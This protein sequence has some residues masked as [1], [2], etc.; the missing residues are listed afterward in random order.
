MSEYQLTVEDLIAK[1]EGMDPEAP[2]RL[3][4]QPNYPFEYTIGEV[5]QAEDGS[6]WIGEG[7]QDG[8]LRS[9]ARDALEWGR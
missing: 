8:Y 9:A 1:L 6:V 5:V 4:M 2:V 3:A 7:T